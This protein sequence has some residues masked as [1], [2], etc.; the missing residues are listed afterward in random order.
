MEVVWWRLERG[1]WL[2]VEDFVAFMIA[3]VGRCMWAWRGRGI[4]SSAP[5]VVHARMDTPGLELSGRIDDERIDE[6][7]EWIDAFGGVDGRIEGAC[8]SKS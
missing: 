4:S 6:V 7:N 5:S 3:T 2:H 8:V 1:V